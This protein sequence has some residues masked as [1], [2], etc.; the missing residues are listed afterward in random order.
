MTFK[1]ITQTQKQMINYLDNICDKKMTLYEPESLPLT[2]GNVVDDK[3][4]SVIGRLTV[5]RI[6]IVLV[7]L[8]SLVVMEFVVGFILVLDICVDKYLCVV[9]VTS[10]GGTTHSCYYRKMSR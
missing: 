5:L 7:E 6:P 4:L 1:I 3:V 8:L 10:V 2:E 9:L